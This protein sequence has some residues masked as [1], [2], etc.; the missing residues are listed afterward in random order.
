MHLSDEVAPAPRRMTTRAV[1]GSAT[2]QPRS[3]RSARMGAAE[4]RTQL[5]DVAADIVAGG[6]VEALTIEAVAAKAGV[7]RPVVYRHFENAERLLDATIDRELEELGGATSAA[8]QG[9]EGIEPRLRAAVTSWMEHFAKSAALTSAALI[10]S[11]ATAGVRRRR[12]AQNRA[13]MTFFVRELRS[14]G[15]DADDA[16]VVAAIMLHGLVGLVSLWRARRVTRSVAIDRFVAITL[17]AVATLRPT[18]R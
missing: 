11:P 3:V 10:E 4:R 12:R 1:A 16:A 5:L 9:L 8:V 6:G 13:S 18:D 15:L 17:G 14:A 7:H 2:P